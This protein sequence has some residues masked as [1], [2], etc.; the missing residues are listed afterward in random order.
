MSGTLVTPIPEEGRQVIRAYGDGGFR[1]SE[2]RHEGAVIVFPDRTV[3]WN[4]EDPEA[5]AA[6]TLAPALEDGQGRILLIGCGER[7]LPPPDGLREAVSAKGMVLEWMDTGAA[8][9]T[10]NILLGDERPV[11]AALI[12]VK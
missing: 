4:V 8:C 11:V 6:D 10:F 3:A 12:P 1:I 7:F 2:T 5:I 9:R